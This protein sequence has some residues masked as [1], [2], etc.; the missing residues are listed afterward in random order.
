MEHDL[1]GTLGAWGVEREVESAVALRAPRLAPFHMLRAGMKARALKSPFHALRQGK[2]GQ[3][4][5]ARL[6]RVYGRPSEGRNCRRDV[7]RPSLGA[8]PAE[9]PSAP[10]G[11]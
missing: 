10:G 8:T 1:A 7:D 2:S 4:S 5:G 6:H 9:D 11:L 3:R